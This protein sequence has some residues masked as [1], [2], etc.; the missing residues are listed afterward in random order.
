[1]GQDIR[2][3]RRGAAVTLTIDR[4]EQRNAI[5]YDMWLRLAEVFRSLGADA[6]ARVLVLRGAG[7]MAFSAGAD[8]KDFK[9]NRSDAQKARRYAAA[10]QG[11]MQSLAA[12]SL[13]T[14][15]MVHGYCVGG[16]CELAIFADV[17]I[18]AEGSRFGIPA[19]RL[20]L[21]IGHAEVA[22][23]VSLVGPGM[24]MY[25]LLS[26]RTL[27]ADEALRAGLIDRLVPAAELEAFTCKLADE[28][29]ALAPLSHSAH[30]RVLA[31]VLRD[32]TLAGVP[33]EERE[34]AFGAF[35][36]EDF[37]EG[38]S[39]FLEKRRPMFRGR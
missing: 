19:A 38:V 9:V 10:A 23:L 32:P 20:G 29:A 33:P 28:I 11:A 36:S 6:D 5:T 21:V 8:I 4:P 35:D 18:A 14:I 39:A 17:R 1:M 25:M 7:E 2:V 31:T 3:E 30:K 13:P 16:G 26:A 12:L 34:A 24:A 15:A 27:E 22:R 37:K